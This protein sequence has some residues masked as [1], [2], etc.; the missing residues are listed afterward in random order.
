VIS[1]RFT[2]AQNANFSTLWQ[3]K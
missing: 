2:K 3:R 1:G